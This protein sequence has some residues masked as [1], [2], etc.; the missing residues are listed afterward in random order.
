VGTPRLV[1]HR[2]EERAR[3]LEPRQPVPRARDLL[4][5]EELAGGEVA[6]PDA[7]DLVPGRVDQLGGEPVI[8]ADGEP[9]EPEVLVL[10]RLDVLVE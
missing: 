10:G 4:V 3:V 6:D 7:E 8:G 5:V 1:G 9:A 2:V